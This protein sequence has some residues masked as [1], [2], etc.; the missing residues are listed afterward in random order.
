[1][2]SQNK[3]IK[4]YLKSGKSLTALDALHEFNCFRI[5]ARVFDL[6][7]QGMNI[8]TKIISITS[9]GKTKRVARYR[10]IRS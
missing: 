8:E 6:K 3:R 1:M 10:L 9:G 2:K 7:S 4:K 5:S